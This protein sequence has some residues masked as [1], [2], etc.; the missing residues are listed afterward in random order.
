[1]GRL[2][3]KVAVVTGSSG[4][5]G[6]AIA[7]AFA[8]EGAAVV[9]NSRDRARTD[10]VVVALT[11]SG[12]KAMAFPADIRD[13]VRVTARRPPRAS[14]SLRRAASSSRSARFS[15]SSACPPAPPIRR[16]AWAGGDDESAGRRVGTGKRQGG[17]PGA[18]LHPC[19]AGSARRG[20]GP[21]Q[22]TFA[23]VVLP[24][25]LGPIR[26]T[27]RPGSRRRSTPARAHGP[28]GGSEVRRLQ[29][30]PSQA[31]PDEVPGNRQ[32]A[33]AD[34]RRQRSRRRPAPSQTHVHSPHLSDPVRT[35]TEAGD[36]C[37][38]AQQVGQGGREPAPQRHL[39]YSRDPAQPPGHPGQRHSRRPRTA[40]S[41]PAHIGLNAGCWRGLLTL[42][43]WASCSR[44][45]AP[46]RRR[47]ATTP[48]T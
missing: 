29:A 31:P 39:L 46:M 41:G 33:G 36:F 11:A 5:I 3:G 32:R 20:G 27:R 18:R 6:R 26:V 23:T 44:V 17:L 24:D 13:P 48:S 45:P 15:A 10:A 30:S 38:P 22:S 14:C 34:L 9:V 40:R 47:T 12:N 19:R 37:R 7:E 8:A 4:G 35:A 43:H 16:Q 42:A 1:M 2:E 28:S 21:V 25:P